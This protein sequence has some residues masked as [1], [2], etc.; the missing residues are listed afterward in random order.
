MIFQ[1]GKLQT[2]AAHR[3]SCLLPVVPADR[4]CLRSIFL[5][6]YVPDLN[7]TDRPLNKE[8]V[9]AHDLQLRFPVYRHI[10]PGCGSRSDPLPIWTDPSLFI[11]RRNEQVIPRQNSEP[12][13]VH[14]IYRVLSPA[15]P[16]GVILQFNVQDLRLAALFVPAQ[17]DRD[18]SGLCIHYTGMI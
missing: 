18:I 13:P 9:N 7:L 6:V 17:A 4:H 15:D 12:L 3:Y 10:F 2:A 8:V 16:R 1:D 11:P 14:Q 5:S